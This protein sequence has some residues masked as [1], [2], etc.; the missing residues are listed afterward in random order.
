[1]LFNELIDSAAE[2]LP[3]GWSIAVNI[4]SGYGGVTL[5]DPSGSDAELSLEGNDFCLDRQLQICIDFARVRESMPPHF[6]ED[7]DIGE[8]E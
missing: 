5:F 1:M 3:E 7:F 8:W 2:N 6:D 4:E